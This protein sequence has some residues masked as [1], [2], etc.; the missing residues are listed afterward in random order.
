MR[1][2]RRDWRQWTQAQQI[3]ARFPIAALATDRP[4]ALIASFP[5]F[6]NHSAK[7]GRTL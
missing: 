7:I 4:A 6:A 1:D 5:S 3:A 2:L